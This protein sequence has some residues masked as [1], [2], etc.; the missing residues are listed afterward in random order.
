M[1]QNI[2]YNT[3]KTKG[4][5]VVFEKYEPKEV[6]SNVPTVILAGMNVPLIRQRNGYKTTDDLIRSNY[7]GAVPAELAVETGAPVFVVAQPGMS[8]KPH[9]SRLYSPETQQ[10]QFET[11]LELAEDR[12]LYM[13]LHSLSTT[14]Y[15]QLISHN[16]ETNPSKIVGTT[17]SSTVTTTRD[18]L[19]GRNGWLALFNIAQYFD[20]P[21][22]PL[23]PLHDQKWHDGNEDETRN[24]NWKADR[25][26]N[27]KSAKWLLGLDTKR[28]ITDLKWK[29]CRDIFSNLP[30]LFVIPDADKVF[31]PENSSQNGGSYP[32]RRLFNLGV[33]ITL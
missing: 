14:T 18:A 24:P 15:P 1:S 30:T 27:P 19:E 2:C 23:Y 31:D 17:M 4:T 29:Y 10:K 11:A 13:I 25:W 16:I 28:S 33:N 22:V 12:N 9:K 7:F 32:Q 26:I 3:G 6:T 21:P 8:G 20:I 5:E